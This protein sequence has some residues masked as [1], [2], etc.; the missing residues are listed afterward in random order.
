VWKQDNWE[1]LLSTLL[2]NTQSHYLGAL[3]VKKIKSEGIGQPQ[4]LLIIDGQQRLTTLSILLYA[5]HKTM[6]DGSAAGRIPTMKHHLFYQR[7]K[8]VDEWDIK[9]VHSINDRKYYEQVINGELSDAD[10]DAIVVGERSNDNKIVQCY[11]YFRE[12]LKTKTE[13]SRSDLFNRLVDK[14]EHILVFIQI[15]DKDNEQSIYDAI[16][17]TGIRLS[18]ADIIKNAIYMRAMQVCGEQQATAL[19]NKYWEN[20]FLNEENG[21]MQFWDTLRATGRMLRANL[22]ILFH[23]IAIIKKWYSPQKNNLS[24]LSDVYKDEVSK[25][26]AKELENFMKEIAEYA[27]IYRDNFIAFDKYTE[28]K[29][30]VPL[31]RLLHILNVLEITTINAILLSLLYK[32]KKEQDKLK[33][34]LR[35][36]ERL[37]VYSMIFTRKSL[38]NNTFVSR[39]FFADDSFI[40]TAIPH[41]ISRDDIIKSLQSI[42]DKLATWLLFW[43]ELYRRF[44]SERY[45]YGCLT[46]NYTL[47]HIM[48][49]KWDTH[50]KDVA[51][52]DD[53]GAVITDE[54]V[55]KQHRDS[56]IQSLGNMTLLKG[57]LNSELQNYSFTKKMD[58]S[59]NHKGIKHYAELGI[60]KD[61]V[62]KYDDGE[63]NWNEQ[64]INARTEE[65]ANDILKIWL[66]AGE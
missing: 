22:E 44:R 53:E 35:K 23:Y 57:K 65:L 56:K 30:D 39:Y 24:G 64:T 38:R 17:S 19:Y 52:V 51:V 50:W 21:D 27:K 6:D 60:T 29:F 8:Q 54:K 40:D 12:E 20:V 18:G 34:E 32:Y 11:K 7:N 28:L 1:E 4:G 47:E 2:D 62:K 37:I 9:I 15:D 58:G 36:V 13:K 41:N 45:D 33:S 48:P 16:N 46:Y 14:E 42:S 26:N 63:K 10:Y 3:I 49:K 55:A 5:L 66:N 31:L 59:E 61:I 25:L 43:I